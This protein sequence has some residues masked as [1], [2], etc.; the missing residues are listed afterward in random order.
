MSL[1]FKGLRCWRNSVEA[2]Y[3]VSTNTFEKQ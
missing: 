1:G 3:K 2:I